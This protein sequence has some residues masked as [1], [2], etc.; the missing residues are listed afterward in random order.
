[1]YFLY[2]RTN[3]ILLAES[4]S[5]HKQIMSIHRKFEQNGASNILHSTFFTS[6]NLACPLQNRP[7]CI[8]FRYLLVFIEASRFGEF[9]EK[10]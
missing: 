7:I 1:M 6:T 3:A 9:T 2:K 4:K 10:L 8:I 5:K